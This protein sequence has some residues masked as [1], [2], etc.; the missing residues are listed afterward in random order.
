MSDVL[1]ET[2]DTNTSQTAALADL[3][4]GPEEPGTADEPEPTPEP[5]ADTE[6]EQETALE[7]PQEERGPRWTPKRVKEM[8][9][10]DWTPELL[11]DAAQWATQSIVT[12]ERKYRRLKQENERFETERK[13][14]I[15]A[16]DSHLASIR[17]LRDKALDPARRMHAL[18][19]IAGDDPHKL[20]E[21]LVISMAGAK[22][23]EDK[24]LSKA[25]VERMLAERLEQQRATQQ[26][27]DST[28][29]FTSQMERGMN[30]AQEFPWLAAR[31]KELG[32]ERT[33]SELM[34][35]SKREAEKLGRPVTVRYIL[36]LVDHAEAK[37]A[38]THVP[39]G[40]GPSGEKS[41]VAAKAA[42]KPA[43]LT[44][45]EQAQPTARSREAHLDAIARSLGV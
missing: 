25:D 20:F 28:A 22:A 31:A 2:S 43:K 41:Q 18:A 11:Q 24:P 40:S 8:S 10:E 33:M 38:R 3:L 5:A 44:E 45:P 17:D 32:P 9:A 16:R 29:A 12:S 26:E 7:P 36:T 14:F 21:D 6:P 23:D 19:Q 37:S 30:D 1:A 27:Q 34:A 35:I 13:T 4:L 15:T 42:K 39:P